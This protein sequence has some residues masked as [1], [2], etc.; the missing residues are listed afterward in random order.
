MI[1]AHL[2]FATIGG[3][4][5]GALHGVPWWATLIIVIIFGVLFWAA[6]RDSDN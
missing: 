3:F 4:A 1:P 5:G 6:S 2:V